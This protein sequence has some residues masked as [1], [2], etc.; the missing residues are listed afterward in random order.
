MDPNVLDKILKSQSEIAT[1]RAIVQSDT[2]ARD[3]DDKLTAEEE[4]EAKQMLNDEQLKRTDPQKYKA[5]QRYRETNLQQ[6][7]TAQQAFRSPAQY[8]QT[9]GALVTPSSH[10]I[11]SNIQQANVIPTILPV[12]KAQHGVALQ[13]SSVGS[14]LLTI[15]AVVRDAAT[16]APSPGVVDGRPVKPQNPRSATLS[17]HPPAYTSAST[18]QLANSTQQQGASPVNSASPNAI[19]NRDIKQVGSHTQDTENSVIYSSS[20][21]FKDIW[22]KMESTLIKSAERSHKSTAQDRARSARKA[23]RICGELRAL[24]RRL[25]PSEVAFMEAMRRTS[26]ILQAEDAKCRVLLDDQMNADDFVRTYSMPMKEPGPSGSTGVDDNRVRFPKHY[27][28]SLRSATPFLSP[29]LPP[30]LPPVGTDIKQG[31]GKTAE[32]RRQFN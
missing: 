9:N 1:I 27:Q 19:K 7:K 10:P 13:G 28:Q 5:Q 29:V 23:I 4:K 30:L 21:D 31:L 26:I 2:F 32:K 18:N 15:P 12:P 24:I 17:S 16:S 8:P 6:L 11:P 20:E 3:D 14:P 25:A 22:Q